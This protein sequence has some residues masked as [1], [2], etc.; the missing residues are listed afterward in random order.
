MPSNERTLVVRRHLEVQK[1]LHL[2]PYMITAAT[3]NIRLPLSTM[4]DFCLKPCAVYI[5]TPLGPANAG[6]E[7]LLWIFNYFC[8]KLDM[9]AA[10]ADDS[11]LIDAFP[12]KLLACWSPSSPQDVNQ[13]LQIHRSVCSQIEDRQAVLNAEDA[14][15]PGVDSSRHGEFYLH[16]LFRSICIIMDRLDWQEPEIQVLRTG[17]D[18]HLRIGPIDFDP[19]RFAFWISDDGDV[20]R[21]SFGKVISLIME[22]KLR[23]DDARREVE[24]P[25]EAENDF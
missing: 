5:T 20:L 8:K 11:V 22:W 9:K 1:R 7:H 12:C 16:P 4:Y 14:L 15:V 25:Q 24:E 21:G 2:S 19:L 13:I 23:E 3:G 6:H 18:E 17:E 10:L